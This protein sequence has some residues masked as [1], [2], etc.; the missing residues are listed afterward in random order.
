MFPSLVTI[1][2]WEKI[3]L[4]VGWSCRYFELVHTDLW[5]FALCH[6]GC[7]KSTIHM[8]LHCVIWFCFAIFPLLFPPFLQRP[9]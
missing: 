8:L 7:V 1:E 9:F 3:P 2:L 6:S 5:G 4:H